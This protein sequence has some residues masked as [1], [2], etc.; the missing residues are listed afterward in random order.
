MNGM[1]RI[2]NIKNA[3]KTFD[4]NWAIVRSMK[5]K[6][7]WIKQVT[8]LSPST[9]LF[10]KYRNLASADNWNE[11]SFNSIYVPQFISELRANDAAREAF[12]Y[13]FNQD[14]LGKN[15]CL[16]CFC[17]NE[18]LC[19]RSIIAGILQGS[20]AN[21][22]TDTDNDYSKYFNMYFNRQT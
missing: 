10:F 15:I 3:D 14:K 16:V 18:Q 6:S 9:N 22:I 2:T 17:P 8:A 11:E 7:E 20:G 12:D 4:E 1:I 21:V 19:H 13:L 5:S